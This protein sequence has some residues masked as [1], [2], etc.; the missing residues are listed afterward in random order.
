MYYGPIF[1]FFE[2]STPFLNLHWFATHLPAGFVPEIVQAIN[3]VLLLSTFFGARILWGFYSVGKLA[4]E[5]WVVLDKLPLWLPAIVLGSNFSLD[6]LN[7]RYL[8]IVWDF[9]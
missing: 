5:L 8:P 3:G 6:C 9:T 1:L 2:L 4:S 7:V